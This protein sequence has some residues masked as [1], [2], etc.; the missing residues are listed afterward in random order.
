LASTPKLDT[1]IG[2]VLARGGRVLL[3][4]DDRQRAASGAGGVLRDIET[5]HGAVT[6]TEVLRFTDPTEGQAS[7]A[8]RAGDPSAVGFYADRSRVHAVTTDTAADL[9]YQG[10]A[11]DTANG[12]DS[13]MIAPTLEMVADLNA[14]ARTD[15]ITAAAAEGGVPGPELVLPN[16]ERV[17]AGDTVITKRNKRTLSMGGTDFVRNNYRWTVNKINA[18]GSLLA[19]EIT[20]GVTR[21]LP[22]WYVTAG[23]LRL[24]YAYTHASVQGM[25]VGTAHTRKGTAHTVVTDRMTRQ[26]LYPTLT[27]ATDGTHAYVVLG[28]EGDPHEVITPDAIQPPTAIEVLTEVIGRDGAARSATTEIRD[29]HDPGLRVGHAAAAYVHA[30]TVGAMTILG[31]E[32]VR[33]IT[34]GAEEAVPGVTTAPA[35]ETVLGHLAVLALDGHDPV[36]RLV[37][38]AAERELDTAMDLAAVLDYR[39]DPTGNHSQRPGALPWV[40]AIPETLTETPVWATYLAARAQLVTDLV[41]ELAGQV[42]GWTRLDAPRWAVPYL[43]NRDLLVDLAVWRA[44]NTVSAEDLRPA[45]ERPRRIALRQYHDNLVE[46]CLAVAGGRDDGANR[47]LEVLAEHGVDVDALTEDEFWPVLVGRLNLAET[48]GLPVRNLLGAATRRGQLPVEQTAAALWWRLAPHLGSVITDEAAG[49]GTR[50]RPTW[51]AIL[52]EHLGERVAERIVTDRLWPTLVARVDAAVRAGHDPA[53]IVAD[54]AGMFAASLD[55]VPEHQWAT[56][57][58]WHLAILTDPAPVDDEEPAHPD[59]AD[60]D[61]QPPTDL[62]TQSMPTNTERPVADDHSVGDDD[63]VPNGD[64]DMPA[65]TDEVPPDPHDADAVGDDAE[66]AVDEGRVLA[67]LSAAAAFYAAEGPRSWVPAYLTGR[68]LPATAAGYA[69][70]TWTALVNHLRQAGCTDKE[71]LAAGLARHSSRGGLIDFFHNRAVLPIARPTDGA[72]VAFIGRKHPD[73]TNDRAP[74]YL[75]SPTTTVFRKSDLPFGLTP[76]QVTRLSEGADLVIVEGPMDALAVNLARPD[77]VAVAPLG[78]ALTP[79]HLTTLNRIAPLTDRRVLLLLDDDKAGRAASVRA[80]RVLVGA[81]VTDADAITL[82]EG[83]D[84]AEL[85]ANRGPNTLAEALDKRHPLADLVVDEVTHRWTDGNDFVEHRINALREAAHLIGT[86]PPAQQTRQASRL[87]EQLDLE[88]LTVIDAILDNTPPDPDA[89][90]PDPTDPLGLPKRPTLSTD[91]QPTPDHGHDRSEM[92]DRWRDEQ[93]RQAR[94]NTAAALLVDAWADRPDLAQRVRDAAAM[95]D[96]ADRIEQ[97][98]QEG[99]DVRQVLAD[100]PVADLEVVDDPA[101]YAA[102][103][104]DPA[105]A[106]TPRDVDEQDLSRVAELITQTWHDTPDLARQVI[107]DSRFPS[108]VRA[109]TAAEIEGLDITGLLV[110]VPRHTVAAMQ[111]KARFAAHAIRVAA[112]DRS[113]PEPDAEPHPTN[114]P[115]WHLDGAA[116]VLRGAWR[117]HPDVAEKLITGPGFDVL[118]DR[119]AHAQQAGLDAGALLETIDPDKIATADVPS[120]SGITAAALTRAAAEAQIPSWTERE[121]GHFADETLAGE[122]AHARQRLDAVVAEQAAAAQ[123]A[124]RLAEEAAAGRGPA[125]TRLEQ[126]LTELHR[127]AQELARHSSLE[128]D[129]RTAIQTA[130]AAA[131]AAAVAEHERNQLRGRAHR[132]RAELDAQITELHRQEAEAHEAAAAA[133]EVASTLDRVP[134]DPAER[135]R[136]AER[137]RSADVLHLR[138]REAALTKDIETAERITLRVAAGPDRSAMGRLEAELRART[139]LSPHRQRQETLERDAQLATPAHSHEIGRSPGVE[140]Q[141]ATQPVPVDPPLASPSIQPGI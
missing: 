26:D 21:V 114:N 138:Q 45:G 63:L 60:A 106:R 37:D 3:V 134:K 128:A 12:V 110:D 41:T 107:V 77:L 1:A 93:T 44:V 19:T 84:P 75:N 25:T 88:Y 52:A 46:R 90:A 9:V 17:S 133:A 62:H 79:G 105:E 113:R 111:E 67:A 29:A 87:A 139:A 38:A 51:T 74:K 6:L 61:R 102:D 120:P 109:V 49:Q 27:R 68:G 76:Q 81:G 126:E 54:A 116:D 40:P 4:G 112:A 58:L 2:F 59:P 140:Y 66:P 121:Y 35:W 50:L 98:Q 15:R 129:W 24:G 117:E 127:T 85:L 135:Q 96:I 48:A 78:T 99:A 86:M 20:R 14:R 10:W 34:A 7:L 47:W 5:T 8:L 43:L 53:H 95:A 136:M 39:L 80:W 33:V 56:V 42:C 132:R 104:L 36:A 118:A 23:F 100:L 18:D 64:L 11:A 83:K 130:Q 94:T 97:L 103:L 73:D 92:A 125:V 124:A 70:A 69:P 115:T 71:I 123:D 89:V 91:P 101:A 31:P 122:L 57:L 119:M 16:G 108:T 65:E 13:V 30:L 22:S 131:A 28:G 32:R 141:I 72:V 82:G 137:I 55:T